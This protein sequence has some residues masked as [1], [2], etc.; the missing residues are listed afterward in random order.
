MVTSRQALR[1]RSERQYPLAPLAEHAAQQLF[2]E[3]AAAVSPGFTLDD[4]NAAV[5]A[6]ICRLLDGLPLAIELAAAR[7]RLLPPAALLRPPGRAAR[8]AQRRSGRPARTAADPARDHGLELRPARPARAGRLHPARRCSPAAGPSRP[9]RPSAAAGRARRPGR[10]V[11]PAGRQP[12]A[13]V[14]RARPSRACTCS[15][16][17][18][19]TPWRSWPPPRTAPT[20]SGATATWVLA[21]SESFWHARDRGIR[22]RARALRPRAG[23][24]PRGGSAGASTPRTSRSAT[25]FLRNTFPYLLRRDAEREAMG[26]LEQLA[27]PRSR[28][29]GCRA[30]AAAGPARPVRGHGRRPRRR[31]AVAGRRAVGSCSRRRRRRPRP[32]RRGRHVRRHGRGLGRGT[33]LR[34]DPARGPRAGRGRP[35]ERRAPPAGDPGAVRPAR[36]ARPW[37]AR[38]SAWRGW[39]CWRGAT[40]AAVGVP[41]SRGPRPTGGG[42]HPTGIAYSLEGLAAVALADGRPAVA[43][44]ALAAAAAARR[45]SVASPLWPVLTPL[46]DDLT[47]RSR[48]R[49]IGC[50]R[51][52]EERPPAGPRPDARGRWRR[53][54]RRLGTVGRS[55]PD[56]HPARGDGGARRCRAGRW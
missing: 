17:C 3:R 2:A 32:R 22:R 38:C 44:R 10:P 20:S 42:G 33:R 13:G 21:M 36:G 4:G 45:D 54:R 41:S 24:P 48:R 12:A 18:A 29:T 28:G 40:S 35:G 49:G 34:G 11:R 52:A 53:A 31:P 27:A 1:L 9:R 56:R 30:R 39:S 16:R 25:L 6:E 14:R 47:L 7:V 50:R 55:Q 8:R 46:V 15:R 5:V 43:A 26:W 51:T 23:Q 19:P 37:S